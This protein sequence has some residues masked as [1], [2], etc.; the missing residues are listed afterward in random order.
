MDKNKFVENVKIYCAKRGV[1][2]T[3]A[4]TESGA[5]KDLLGKIAR[6]G[7]V[8]SVAKVQML[9]QYL[10]CTVSDLLGEAPSGSA[11]AA[12]AVFRYTPSER[13]VPYAVV[14]AER[15]L[16]LR[17]GQSAGTKA[18]CVLPRLQGQRLRRNTGRYR[19]CRSGA[20]SSFYG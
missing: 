4:C 14:Y 7:V 20:S 19:C 10:G 1:K 5:G 17:Y 6:Q 8:P 13:A 15:G 2:P 11:K 18:K 12:D 9:A 16:L 3:I